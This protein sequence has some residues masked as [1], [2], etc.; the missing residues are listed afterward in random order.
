MATR[1]KEGDMAIVTQDQPGCDGNVGRLVRVS[2][3]LQPD[4]HGRPAWLIYPITLEPW[5]FIDFDGVRKF[6]DFQHTDIEHPDI[7]LLPIRPDAEDEMENEA[8][9]VVA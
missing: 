3:P 7:W 1:C 8:L 6:A 9:E 4:R 5:L 2:G